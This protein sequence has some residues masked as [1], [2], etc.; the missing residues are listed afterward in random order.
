MTKIIKLLAIETS[1]DSCSVALLKNN[2]ITSLSHTEPKQHTQ[3]ILKMV[4]QLLENA[5]VSL[6][7]CDG[8]AF[9][10]GPGSFTG[11][12]I[13]STVIQGFGLATGKPV[14]PVSTLRTIAQ[15]AY[16]LNQTPKVFALLDAHMQEYYGGLFKVDENG[17]MQN[18]S[19]EFLKTNIE[20][21][22]WLETQSEYNKW[23]KFE[24][25]P[26]AEDTVKIAAAEWSSGGTISAAEINLIYLRHPVRS[27]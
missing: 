22:A 27:S 21:Q 8:F 25:L 20:W 6:N 7:E 17:V 1:T 24:S 23:Q 13:A 9:G 14:I 10:C 12:R 16:R 2:Q 18:V 4:N 3:L 15:A 26:E 5:G 19:G 11:V